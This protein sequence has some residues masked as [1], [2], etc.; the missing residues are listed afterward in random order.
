MVVK[1]AYHRAAG[2]SLPHCRRTSRRRPERS[3]RKGLFSAAAMALLGVSC[4]R[5]KPQGTVDA[6]LPAPRSKKAL[7]IFAG[8][9]SQPATTEAVALY[10][11]LYGTPVECTFGGSGAVL[12]QVRIERFGDIYLP[13]SNEYMDVAEK[14]G[15]VL[16]KTR[17][18]ICRLVP[19]IC[20]AA[21]NPLGIRSVA[22]LAR[23]GLRLTIGDPGSVCLGRIAVAAFRRA[24]V[25]GKVRSNIVTYASDCQQIINLIRLGEV[26]AAIGY[27]VFGRQSPELLDVVLIE[28]GTPVNIP[29]AVIVYSKRP[30]E[31]Q[32][33]VDFLA[34]PQGKDIFRKHGYTIDNP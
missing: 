15:L 16:P 4:A 10:E 18:V 31:A 5:E 14:D 28:G 26:D 7:V 2:S 11:K 30:Q 23:P 8:A 33:L 24:G 13:G 21:G 34:G 22:D 12:N 17:R 9:A 20:V 27:A 1:F 3:W 6:P 25:Y 29:A 19:A 32:R